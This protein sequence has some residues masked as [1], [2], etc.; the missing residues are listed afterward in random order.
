MMFVSEKKMLIHR[1][2]HSSFESSQQPSTSTS[3]QLPLNQLP[4]QTGRGKLSNSALN[5]SVKTYSFK[6]PN[7][8]VDVLTYLSDNRDEIGIQLMESISKKHGVKWY[9]TIYPLFTK[10]LEEERVESTPCFRSC[11]FTLLQQSDFNQQF[12]RAFESIAKAKSNFQR[13]GS[14]WNFER[15][16]GV[17]LNIARYVPL[18]ASSYIP[19]PKKLLKKKA[20][21]N[22]QNYDQ[23][24]FL[25]SVLAHL[26]VP[27]NHRER[28]HPY[29]QFESELDMSG[30]EYPVQLSKL[31]RFE[32]QNDIS[33]NVF[34]Y[35]G[36]VFPLRIT[37]FNSDTHINLLYLSNEKTNHFCLISNLNRLLSSLTHHEHQIFY[38]NFCLHRFS[39]QSLL[40][41]HSKYCNMNEPQKIK[42]PSE[43]FMHFKNYHF[44]L[45]VP[46]TIYADFE[47]LNKKIYRCAPSDDS[48]YT[49][50]TAQHEC[51]G[52][53]YV[54]VNS[55]GE[56]HKPLVVYRGPNAVTHFL[57]SILK[58]EEELQK[59]MKEI[60]PMIIT[61][62]EE[63]SFQNALSARESLIF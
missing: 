29:K 33:I 35:E 31:D 46:F 52:Y 3:Q 45:K 27:L 62:E 58:E 1:N 63:Q 5:S 56:M 26:H 39:K 11:T 19:L 16:L 47:S 9:I 6:I 8:H 53:S 43:K 21:V 2:S 30:I 10:M 17:E 60:K 51:S 42:M 25:W 7:V 18:A 54:V 13:E 41:D 12:N 34:G 4:L 55:R 40:D 28:V 49:L 38:C 23:K 20:L 37:K 61:P 36:E 32:K 24:C 44:M 22:I 59:I 14:N 15:I 57:E 50:K 48:P